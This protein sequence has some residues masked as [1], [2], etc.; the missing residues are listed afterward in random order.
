[1]FE[2]IGNAQAAFGRLP[3]TTDA[4]H[5][6]AMINSSTGF[7]EDTVMEKRHAIPSFDGL[8]NMINL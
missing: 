1:M 2:S 8:F 5:E 3:F 4:I 7:H 6:A